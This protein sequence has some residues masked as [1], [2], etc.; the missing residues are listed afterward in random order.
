VKFHSRH[1]RSHAKRERD[2]EAA[3]KTLK[4]RLLVVLLAL[5]ALVLVMFCT[6]VYLLVRNSIQADIDQFVLD[7]ALL[8]GR[9]VNPS[10]PAWI[11]FEERDWHSRRFTPL[12][13]TF[14]T[15]W[16]LLFLSRRL[17]AP[18][19]PSE[20]V[21]REA[22]H[23]LGAA[24]H[25]V[26]GPDGKRYRMATVSV[27]RD[28]RL[29]CYA[30][31]A[32]PL[33]ERDRDLR[34]L[35]LWLAG[36]S[37]FTWL[38]ALVAAGYLLQQWRV[39]LTALSET[40]RRVS[41]QNLS[42]QRLFEPPDVPE[43]AQVAQAF[44]DLLDK[45]E[46]AHT[47]QQRFVGDASHELRTPL[48]ILRGEIDVALRR[49][50]TAAEYRDVLQ[51]NKEE[52]ERMSR[53]VENLLALARADAG[54]ALAR[55]EPVDVAGVARDVCAKLQPLADAQNVP[56]RCEAAEEAQVSGDPL[57]LERI[58]FNLIENAVRYSPRGESVSV[59]IRQSGEFVI[60]E[61][62]DHGHGIPAEHLPHIFERFYRVDKA[63]SR[64]FGG[65]GLGL[66]IAKTLVE[67]HDGRIEVRRGSTFTVGSASGVRIPPTKKVAH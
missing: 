7:K 35:L 58:F 42:R 61:I 34:R 14:D 17:A 29:L 45:L 54:Q 18:I 65:A 60:G 25:D 44:N 1:S 31:I 66:S 26:V 49:E 40:A 50:R 12:G 67:A 28:G 43:L 62:E 5:L 20:Q 19:P 56:L 9:E 16:N 11:L 30:Q 24:V 15:N 27:L 63:R 48:T 13:Q 46:A 47:T 51:S 22:T 36:G 59:R 32:V 64:E 4:A 55:R 57:A 6:V 37:V 8:L 41:V 39:P 38:G 3:V 33:L 21:K 2:D 23:P 53:L 52:I 10:N